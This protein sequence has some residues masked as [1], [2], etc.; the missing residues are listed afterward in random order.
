MGKP[1][2]P[3]RPVFPPTLC[4]KCGKITRPV[5][6]DDKERHLAVWPVRCSGCRKPYWEMIA[7][8]SID[9]HAHTKMLAEFYA[10]VCAAHC[11]K[12]NYRIEK[13]MVIHDCL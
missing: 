4:H 9:H 1:D 3:K 8:H 11:E 5:E 10:Y 7:K 2:T 13:D 6:C 12:P